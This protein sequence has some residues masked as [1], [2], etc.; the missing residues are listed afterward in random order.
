MYSRLSMPLRRVVFQW[1]RG[2]TLV[3][4][5][6][7]HIFA[8]VDLARQTKC[9]AGQAANYKM[10]TK[11]GRDQHLATPSH[12]NPNAHEPKASHRPH[13]EKQQPKATHATE[14]SPKAQ[15]ARSLQPGL[16]GPMGRHPTAP[17]EGTGPSYGRERPVLSLCLPIGP[18]RAMSRCRSKDRNPASEPSRALFDG[19]SVWIRRWHV[20]SSR[21]RRIY[22]TMLGLRWWNE[23]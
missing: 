19:T 21:P 20:P 9:Q 11:I 13:K 1:W 16:Y 2:A 18:T 4:L 23:S 22:E 6:L 17:R 8:L 15:S 5:W 10:Q 14:S 3:R 7:P 12:Q